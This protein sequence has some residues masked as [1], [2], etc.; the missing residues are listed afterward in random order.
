MDIIAR[1]IGLDPVEF[2][3]RNIIDEG[4]PS[5]MGDKWDHIYARQTFEQAVNASGWGRNKPGKNCGRGMAVYER[6]APTGKASAAITIETD[7]SIT[8]LTGCPDIG[9]GFYTVAQQIVCETLRGYR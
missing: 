2:R 6:G 5:P 4:D 1:E 7:G 3:R 9:T 8:L